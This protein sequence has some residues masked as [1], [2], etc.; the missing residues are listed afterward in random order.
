MMLY[1]QEEK[2]GSL[3]AEQGDWLADT[4]DEPDEQELEAHYMYMEKIQE[5]LESINDTYV[6]ETGDSNITLGPP[7]MCDNEGQAHQNTKAPKDEHVLLASLIVN[8]KLDI[9]ENKKIS[10]AIKE[11]KHVSLSRA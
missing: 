4:D 3:S 8:F 7:D 2:G 10:I 9:D 1:K 11:S 6:V 5:Q